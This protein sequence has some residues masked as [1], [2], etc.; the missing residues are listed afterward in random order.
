MTAGPD[1]AAPGRGLFPD[2]LLRTCIS[3][4]FCLSACPTYQDTRNEASSPRGR[5]NLMR[6]LEAGTLVEDDVR[7]LVAGTFLEGK[8][9]VRTSAATG[10]GIDALREALLALCQSTPSRPDPGLFRM[11]IDRAFTVAGHGTV[12]TGTVASGRVSTGDDV[13]WHRHGRRRD[14]RTCMSVP[15]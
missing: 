3:C 2:D 7:N 5:I 11:A 13:H 14:F 1:L 8:P 6:A 15:D 4:G 10:E 12:V 9:I